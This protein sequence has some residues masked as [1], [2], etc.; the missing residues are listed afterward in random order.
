MLRQEISEIRI[1]WNPKQRRTGKY[2]PILY[3]ETPEQARKLIR[4]LQ[5]EL[6]RARDARN[7]ELALELTGVL[8]Q[9]NSLARRFFRW[10]QSDQRTLRSEEE[11]E[12]RK[13]PMGF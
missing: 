7:S 3:L 1:R 10:E 12:I 9:V 2:D 8:E 5:D 4:H 6:D 11:S 13:L